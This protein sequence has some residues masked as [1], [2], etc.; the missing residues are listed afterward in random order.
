MSNS[1]NYITFEHCTTNR[2]H[3]AIDVS[4]SKIGFSRTST[5]P[6]VK[7]HKNTTNVFWPQGRGLNP[8]LDPDGGESL[9]IPLN[10]IP[11]IID[12]LNEILAQTDSSP[13][14]GNDEG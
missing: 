9:L 3:F 11:Q 12:R 10:M 13:S 1:K 4:L 6:A 7:I 5:I 8:A 2:H 14:T